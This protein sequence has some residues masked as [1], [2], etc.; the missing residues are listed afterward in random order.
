[1]YTLFRN[2]S[3]ISKHP[4]KQKIEKA[5]IVNYGLNDGEGIVMKEK[6]RKEEHKT[7][8]TTYE[9]F[10]MTRAL[11]RLASDRDFSSCVSSC[12]GKEERR[13]KGVAANSVLVLRLVGEQV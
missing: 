7:I 9:S 4:Y 13:M 5:I 1:M 10:T 8:D 11:M 3:N 6:V 12:L 2:A